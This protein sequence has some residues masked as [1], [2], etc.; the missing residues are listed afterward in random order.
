MQLIEIDPV[1]VEPAQARF[2][3]LHDVAPRR[4]AQ[5][6]G[7][8]HRQP[9]FGG[10]H[11]VFAPGTEKVTQ[12]FFGAALVAVR[13]G[14]VDQRDTDI[15]RFVHHQP[16]GLAIDAAAEIVGAEAD[17]GHLRTRRSEPAL[18]HALGRVARSTADIVSRER[19]HIDEL[20]VVR[21]QRHDLH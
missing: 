12:D 7:A 17:E 15:E 18:L 1:G 5:F 9:E 6:V 11:D 14:G 8:I 19:R 10:Q 20:R 13:V 16:R 21:R 4:A 2:D 3:R